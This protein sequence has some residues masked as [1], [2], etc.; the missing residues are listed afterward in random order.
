MSYR[1]VIKRHMLPHITVRLP[2]FFELIDTRLHVKVLNGKQQTQRETWEHVTFYDVVVRRLQDKRQSKVSNSTATTYVTYI[3][4]CY[5]NP[6]ELSSV[7]NAKT[8][9]VE[10]QNTSHTV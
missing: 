8:A 5:V 1:Y 4:A 7:N 9:C 10:H 2:L 6:L 3:T